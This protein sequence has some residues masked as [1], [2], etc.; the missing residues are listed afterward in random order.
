MHHKRD[1]S[2][3]I[4]FDWGIPIHKHRLQPLHRMPPLGGAGLA[5]GV[6]VF[7]KSALH[8][9]PFGVALRRQ[10]AWGFF[11]SSACIFI[12]DTAR[13]M[14]K[15]IDAKNLD[16]NQING[17]AEKTELSLLNLIQLYAL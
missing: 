5:N 11:F 13:L 8:G 15:F 10:A 2:T 6:L 12:V 4:N 16:M 14:S 3:L 1:K 9:P 7:V 17:L